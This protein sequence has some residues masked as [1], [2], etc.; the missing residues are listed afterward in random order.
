MKA[1][2]FMLL[3]GAIAACGDGGSMDEESAQS[4]VM[5][6]TPMTAPDEA[7]A[8]GSPMMMAT[9]TMPGMGMMGTTGMM[10]PMERAS[11]R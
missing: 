11:G 2:A 5:G 10:A 4:G 9:P 3:L 6:S 1:L 8:S 7:M